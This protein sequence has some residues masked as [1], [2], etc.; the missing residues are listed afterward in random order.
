[1]ALVPKD[2][3]EQ[4]A[5]LEKMFTLSTEKLM[6]ITDHFVT[7]LEKGSCCRDLVNCRIVQRRREHCSSTMG[8]SLTV[9]NASRL[10]DGIS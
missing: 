2:L 6:T 7:Q 4:L 5:D 8:R 10:G 1:M 9:A 3:L